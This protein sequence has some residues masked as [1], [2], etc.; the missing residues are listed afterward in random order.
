[1]SHLGNV[2]TARTVPGLQP[3]VNPGLRPGV[4]E[5]GPG[6]DQSD[7]PG[8]VSV[9]RSRKYSGV[10]IDQSSP[11]STLIRAPTR[12]SSTCIG[13]LQSVATP[14]GICYKEPARS[15]EDPAGLVLY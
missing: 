7:L 15:S 9:G 8:S 12:L 4:C 6:Q 11:F 5:D 2:D 13:E 14:A 3:G 1:M 10:N